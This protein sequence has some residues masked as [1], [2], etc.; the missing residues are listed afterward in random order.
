MGRRG[1]QTEEMSVTLAQ[2]QAILAKYLQAEQDVIEGKRVRVAGP[3]LEREVVLEDLEAVRKGRLEWER[4]VGALL[5]AQR[6]GLGIGGL[7]VRVAD[8]GGGQ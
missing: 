5:A 3:G 4:R 2:A 1:K 7:S 6:G 8:F